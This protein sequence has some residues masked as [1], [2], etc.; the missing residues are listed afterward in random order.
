MSTPSP[1][2]RRRLLQ[3]LQVTACDWR[4]DARPLIRRLAGSEA[5]APAARPPAAPALRLWTAC[6]A[7]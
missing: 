7:Y 3:V 1:L 5:P 6:F 4:L 2:I